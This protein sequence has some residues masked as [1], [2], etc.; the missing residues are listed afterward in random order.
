VGNRPSSNSK[1]KIGAKKDGKLVA[2]QLVNY[3]TGGVGTG[4]GASGPAQSMYKCDNISTE[5]Y[6]VF[7]NAGPSAAF[8][9]PGPPQAVFAFEQAIDELAEKCGMD[10]LAFREV[11]DESEARRVQ[12][13]IGAEKIGWTRRKPPGSDSGTVKRGIGVAQ[14]IWYRFSSRDSNC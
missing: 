14:A 2:I 10:P 11:N 8:R 4:A 13:R 1:Y 12:R 6:D 5:D 3:G 7:I 9:P